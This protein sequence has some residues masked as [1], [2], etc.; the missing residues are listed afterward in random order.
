MLTDF[1]TPESHIRKNYESRGKII[2]DFVKINDASIEPSDK[3]Y[4]SFEQFEEE[5]FNGTK[6]CAGFNMVYGNII[7]SKFK[8]A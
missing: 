5:V 1:E 3:Q 7:S 8:Y 6:F 2:M 4:H